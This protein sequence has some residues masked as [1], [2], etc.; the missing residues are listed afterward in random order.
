LIRNEPIF[1]TH[2][3]G[4]VGVG[5]GDGCVIHPSG[6]ILRIDASWSRT[7][8]LCEDDLSSEAVVAM[9]AKMRARTRFDGDRKLTET[10]LELVRTIKDRK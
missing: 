4:S 2:D 3:D 10:L 8:N 1:Y 5:L 7:A 9:L 6:T